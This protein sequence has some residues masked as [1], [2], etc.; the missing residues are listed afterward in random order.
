MDTRTSLLL[1]QSLSRRR[2][3]ASLA[4]GLC[5]GV[6]AT[7][8]P[9]AVAVA[10]H[11]LSLPA[12]LADAQGLFAAEGLDVRLVEE[13]TGRECLQ[14]LLRGEVAAATSAE[15]PLALAALRGG[16]FD[17]VATMATSG[18][19]NKFIVRRD[20]GVASFDKLVGRRV[21]TF[22]ASSAH[23]FAQTC[24]L[25]AGVDPDAVQLVDVSP[26]DAP[27]ALR[28][29]RVDA[30]AIFEPHAWRALKAMGGR[31]DVLPSRRL[32][33]D[34]WNLAVASGNARLP[35]GTLRSLCRALDRAWRLIAATPEL[36]RALLRGR[37]AMEQEAVDWVWPDLHFSLELRQSLVTGLESQARWALRNRLAT[38]ALPN[39]LDH[40]RTAPLAGMRPGAVAI[41]T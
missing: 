40:I 37:L 25:F 19:F 28:D 38:G 8:G 36:G 29:G 9:L 5:A 22:F 31:A 30:L 11:P 17:I 4:L 23:Y 13:N 27:Q 34:T 12:Y 2:L 20:S 32:V 16:G 24:L 14:R 21:G 15:L 35:D 39:F 41:V 26:Q 18:N 7:R 1:C 3:V 33:V 10:R 6:A